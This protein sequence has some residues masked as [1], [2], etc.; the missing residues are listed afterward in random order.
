MSSQELQYKIELLKLNPKI[1]PLCELYFEF[2]VFWKR[3]EQLHVKV[4]E[5]L[6]RES[7]NQFGIK[8]PTIE[9]SI[10]N[11]FALFLKQ[12]DRHISALVQWMRKNKKEKEIS[13]QFKQLEQKIGHL[14]LEHDQ[15]AFA[16][17]EKERKNLES[18]MKQFLESKKA[19][20]AY[21]VQKRGMG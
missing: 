8:S 15:M 9:F 19:L 10:E 21:W 5:K 11:E 4:F 3:W 18:H 12:R 16:L 13:E 20:H 17:F 14:L 6:L 7:Q 2:S 1:Q